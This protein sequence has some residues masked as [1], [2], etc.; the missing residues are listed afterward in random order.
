MVASQFVQEHESSYPSGPLSN[1]FLRRLYRL[2]QKSDPVVL[3]LLT[4]FD[5]LIKEILKNAQ[6]DMV[7]R[8][9]SL[10]HSFDLVVEMD[11]FDR[12]HLRHGFYNKIQFV[13]FELFGIQPVHELPSR[14][15][16]Q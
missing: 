14:Q 2:P 4:L 3:Q 1:Q 11:Q 6:E 15:E 5:V 7:L 16:V 13:F 8:L 9:V 12:N 10:V